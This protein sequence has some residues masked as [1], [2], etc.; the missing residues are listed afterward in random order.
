MIQVMF[1]HH[2]R[3]AYMH[4]ILNDSSIMGE[5]RSVHSEFSFPCKLRPI[6]KNEY[7][8]EVLIMIHPQQFMRISLISGTSCMDAV[9]HMSEMRMMHACD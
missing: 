4:R 8:G 1:M 3:L 9:D 7:A 5:I 2:P 6:P